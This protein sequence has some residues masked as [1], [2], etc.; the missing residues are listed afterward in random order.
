MCVCVCVC[1]IFLAL[2]CL[3]SVKWVQMKGTKYSKGSITV[4]ESDIIP[5]FGLIVDLLIVNDVCM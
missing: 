4:I 3:Y 1:V 2:P 5:R